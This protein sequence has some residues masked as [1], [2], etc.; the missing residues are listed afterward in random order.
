MPSLPPSTAIVALA[1]GH[2]RRARRCCERPAPQVG[3]DAAER[4]HGD[5]EQHRAGVLAERADDAGGEPA[6]ERGQPG[7]VAADGREQPL[8][9]AHAATAQASASAVANGIAW[10]FSSRQ[11]AV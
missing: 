10:F 4:E 5:D 8:A 2:V 7:G 1:V 3:A 11:A 9:Q 6:A